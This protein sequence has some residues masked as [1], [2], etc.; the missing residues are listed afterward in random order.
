MY[1]NVSLSNDKSKGLKKP[2]EKSLQIWAMVM[3]DHLYLDFPKTTLGF[4][5]SVYHPWATQT[6]GLLRRAR[7]WRTRCTSWVWNMRC[8][9]NVK[10]NVVTVFRL[11][12][13]LVQTPELLQLKHHPEIWINHVL[14]IQVSWPSILI[15]AALFRKISEPPKFQP[16][17]VSCTCN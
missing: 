17:M 11:P 16:E 6:L 8:K 4:P 3:Y 13:C 7:T 5:M 2:T 12:K 10:R 1:W 9:R 14:S 15:H